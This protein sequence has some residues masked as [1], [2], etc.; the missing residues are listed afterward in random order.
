MVVISG[1]RNVT[2]IPLPTSQF[3]GG[4]FYNPE[5]NAGGADDRAFHAAMRSLR[6]T[7]CCESII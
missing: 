4:R 2:E 1:L 3:A 5:N 7:K 6:G